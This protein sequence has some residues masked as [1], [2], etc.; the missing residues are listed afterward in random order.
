MCGIAG[1]Y[2]KNILKKDHSFL[3]ELKSMHE[4]IRHRGPD[5]EGIWTSQ[6]GKVGL[7]HRRLSIIDTSETGHQPMHAQD[8][9]YTITYNGEIYN[10]L[11]L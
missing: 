3:Q 11:E 8:G 10:Y 5:G 9:R 2:Q 6:D 1:I 4:L 7:C